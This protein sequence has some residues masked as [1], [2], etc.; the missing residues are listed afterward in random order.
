[1]SFL[2]P[3]WYFIDELFSIVCEP[4]LNFLGLRRFDASHGRALVKPNAAERGIKDNKNI[5]YNTINLEVKSQK[6]FVQSW[7]PK[8]KK[9][10]AVCIWVHGLSDY[11]GRFAKQA[12][13]LLNEGYAVFAPD[14]LGFGRSDGL[15]GYI[16]DIDDLVEGVRM[17]LAWADM[18]LNFKDLPKFLV[19]I[20]MGGHICLQYSKKY[21]DTIKGMAMMCPFIDV[22]GASEPSPI[23][24]S[25]APVLELVVGRLPAV[26]ANRGKNTSD[27][28]HEIEFHDDVLTYSGRLRV[29]SGMALLRSQ[30]NLKSTLGDVKTPF[31]VCHGTADRAVAYKGSELLME[32]AGSKDKT[33][34]TYKNQEHDLLVEPEHKQVK[35]DITNWLNSR[36]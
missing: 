18:T 28:M 11:G 7:I 32:K 36:V 17:T 31:L 12:D 33:F 24:V 35:K 6:I 22:A 3:L 9:I 15:H 23:L 27:I 25:I 30:S 5:I 2:T 13:F 1:M 26:A 16:Q 29:G 14:H 20:S 21:P 8:N 19:G 34:L 10:K 4:T